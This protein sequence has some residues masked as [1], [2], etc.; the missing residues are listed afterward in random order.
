M[1][2]GAV[3]TDCSYVVATAVASV[4]YVAVG[5]VI[6][7]LLLFYPIMSKAPAD[8]LKVSSVSFA[9]LDLDLHV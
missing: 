1:L 8:V 9:Q 2:I 4:H 6:L 3:R 5:T 7:D